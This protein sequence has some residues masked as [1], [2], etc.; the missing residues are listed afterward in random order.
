MSDHEEHREHHADEP[1]LIWPVPVERPQLEVAQR[2]EDRD[3]RDE[4]RRWREDSGQDDDAVDERGADAP[5]Q[6]GHLPKRR[7]RVA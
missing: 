4:R 3:E 6:S 2:G 5:L 7:S 1:G